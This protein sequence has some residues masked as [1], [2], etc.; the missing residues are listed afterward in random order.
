[1]TSSLLTLFAASLLA[2]APVAMA[3]PLPDGRYGGSFSQKD[4]R[5]IPVTLNL[6]TQIVSARTPYS[7]RFDEPWSCTFD[8]Q[9]ASTTIID[10]P[11]GKE[12]T[13]SYSLVGQGQGRCVTL[14]QGRVLLTPLSDGYRAELIQRN[15]RTPLY[16]LKLEKAN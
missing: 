1:M 7:L 8:L 14:G 9:Y 11:A 10:T 4:G 13:R 16:S 2:A 12:T 3:Q 6:G 15:E 5:D